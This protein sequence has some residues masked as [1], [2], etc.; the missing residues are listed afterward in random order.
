MILRCWSYRVSV[1][2]QVFRAKFHGETEEEAREQMEDHFD[3]VFGG[4]PEII[5]VHEVAN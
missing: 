2:G 4:I 3:I 5:S 1:R